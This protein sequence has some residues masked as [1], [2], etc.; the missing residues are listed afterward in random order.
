LRE[1]AIEYHRHG[2]TDALVKLEVSVGEVML[3]DTSSPDIVI[4]APWSRPADESQA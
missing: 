2:A 3:G 4:A 1:I